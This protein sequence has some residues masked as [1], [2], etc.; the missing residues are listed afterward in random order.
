MGETRNVYKPL[1]GTPGGKKTLRR[2]RSR[3]EKNIKMNLKEIDE[4]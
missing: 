4:V 1:V 2:P 3:W